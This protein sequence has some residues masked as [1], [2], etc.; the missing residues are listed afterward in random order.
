MRMREIATVRVRYGYRKILV[1]LQREGW[2]VGKTMVSRLYRE[3]GLALRRTVPRKRRVAVER[4]ERPKATGPN[5]A[6]SLDFVTD[7]LADG[8][9]FLALT[10]MDVH[11]RE[12][13]AIELGQSLKEQDVV[14]V[15]Q[16]IPR[17][18]VGRSGCSATTDRSSPVKCWTCGPIR[19][20]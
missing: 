1:L 11:T 13:L 10:V 9:R 17:D 19:T 7:Q 6:W 8:R 3:E 12:S 4:R 18:R 20:G 5:Q 14:R 2:A 15:L 16:S